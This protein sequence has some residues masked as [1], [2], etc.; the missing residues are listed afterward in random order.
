[1]TA[2]VDALDRAL[3]TTLAARLRGAYESGTPVAPI[4]SEIAAGDL[5][6]AYGIQETNTETW[7]G[8][9]RRLVGRKI[10]LT[11]KA[12]QRQLGVDQPDYGM[13]FD[14]MALTSGAE[15]APGR[16]L[17]AKVEAEVAFVMERDLLHERPTVADALGAIAYALPALEIVDSRIANWDI[18]ILDTIADNASS[19]LFVLG[20][21]AVP[22][23]AFDLRLCGMVLRRN[24]EAA[25]FGAGAACLGNPLTALLWL[26]ER[27][28]RVGRPLRAGDVVLS[29]AL[30]PMVAAAPGD[31]FEACIDGLGEVAVTFANGE[32]Q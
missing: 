19:G 28:A 31:R 16:L 23:G 4:R 10:G 20:D 29:G 6:S 14:S 2:G 7:L 21:R 24:G 30:G 22:L 15:I 8:S 25:S 26:A 27:M 1:V 9:G 12:V 5:D 18:G 13:L 3:V 32:V 17:Q 11:A